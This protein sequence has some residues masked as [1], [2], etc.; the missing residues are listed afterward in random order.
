MGRNL[1]I[2]GWP[3]CRIFFYRSA[4]VINI[5]KYFEIVFL[6]KFE[7]QLIFLELLKILFQM[8]KLT[9]SSLL[10]Y[11][12]QKQN[13]S[14]FTLA[15]SIEEINEISPKKPKLMN[16]IREGIKMRKSNIL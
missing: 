11:Y 1:W 2:A 10:N 6:F 16:P 9:T 13:S 7:N 3:A 15:T 4:N 14:T 5:E 12:Q 8:N